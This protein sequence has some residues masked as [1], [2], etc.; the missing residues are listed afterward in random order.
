MAQ[1]VEEHPHLARELGVNPD[2]PGLDALDKEKA[3]FLIQ[4]VLDRVNPQA[5]AEQR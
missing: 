2:E 5:A 1:L 3:G 4:T